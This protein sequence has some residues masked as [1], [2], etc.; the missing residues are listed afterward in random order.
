MKINLLNLHEGVNRFNLCIDPEQLRIEENKDALSLFNDKIDADVEIQKFSDKY[1]IKVGLA[2]M[3]Q[4]TCDRCVVEYNQN[5]RG[6]FQLIYTK[7]ASSQS[8]DDD[9]RFLDEKVVEIDLSDDIRENLLLMIPMKRLC[10]EDC[11]GLCPT[12]GAN[13]NDEMCHCTA[14]AIDPRWEKLKNLKL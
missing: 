13:L 12:C 2:T 5:F 6:K 14:E 1:F 3:S 7:H 8:S 4:L 9:Y 10:R 11:A